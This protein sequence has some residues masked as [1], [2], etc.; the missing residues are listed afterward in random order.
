MAITDTAWK[1]IEGKNFSNTGV[2]G[3]VRT[4][5]AAMK[6][7]SDMGVKNSKDQGKGLTGDA[8]AA[9]KSANDA[10]KALVK[11]EGAL[12]EVWKKYPKLLVVGGGQFTDL[13]K[14]LQ[15]FGTEVHDEWAE[16]VSLESRLKP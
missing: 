4:Y 13:G 11:V 6:K 15:K 9:A 10:F 16:V 3:H 12:K 8:K 14:K 2:G 7:L 1:T 5:E